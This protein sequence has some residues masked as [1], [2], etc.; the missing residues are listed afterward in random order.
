MAVA[1]PSQLHRPVFCEE[2]GFH[3][4]VAMCGVLLVKERQAAQN[5][6]YDAIGF[7]CWNGTSVVG[8]E[9]VKVTPCADGHN[10]A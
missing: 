5:L 2:D 6:G 8:D 4:D 3:S 7:V 9:F 10:Q 1:E